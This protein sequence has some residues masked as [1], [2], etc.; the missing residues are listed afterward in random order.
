M[1]LAGGPVGACW[2]GDCS[3]YSEAIPACGYPEPASRGITFSSTC[4]AFFDF[5][6]IIGELELFCTGAIYRVL[7]QILISIRHGEYEG[8]NLWKDFL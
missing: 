2:L 7:C 3:G 8:G 6:I 5:Y 4:R 1:W